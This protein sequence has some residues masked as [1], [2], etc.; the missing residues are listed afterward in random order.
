ME[1]PTPVISNT[2]N[3][4]LKPHDLSFTISIESYYKCCLTFLWAANSACLRTFTIFGLFILLSWSSQAQQTWYLDNVVFESGATATGSFDYDASTFAYTNIDIR[5]T[6]STNYG[7]P[8]YFNANFSNATFVI[9]VIDEVDLDGEPALYFTYDQALPAGGG[10]VNITTGVASSLATCFAPTCITVL[11]PY[12]TLVSGRVTTDPPPTALC[13]DTTVTLDNAGNASISTTDID[14][15]S[16]D[17]AAGFI[18]SLDRT[19]FTCADIGAN[20]VTLTVTDSNG[21]I[22]RCTATVTVTGSDTVAPTISCPADIVV[23]NDPNA[24]NSMVTVPAPTASDDCSFTLTND[25][26]GT[27]DAS[28][29]YPLGTTTV[30]WTATDVGGNQNTCSFT[31]TVNDTEA[32]SITCPDDIS[33]SVDSGMCN[34]IV[35]VPAP[36][37]SDNCSNVTI[38]NDFNNTADASGTY[39]TGTTTVTWTAT[40][41]VGNMTTCPQNI[42]VNDTEPPSITCAADINVNVDVGMCNA[43]LS[44]LAPVF[45]DNCPNATI[46]NDFT[47]TSDA[48]GSYP[49]GTTLVTWTA[50]DASGNSNTCIQRI[51]VTESVA[52]TISCPADSNPSCPQT[53]TYAS[54]TTTDN[55][56]FPAVPQSVPGFTLLGTFGDSTYFISN[57][58][59]TGAEAFAMAATNNYD[60]LTINSQEE[61]DYIFQQQLGLEQQGLPGS[62]GIFLGYNDVQTEGSFVW[63]SGQPRFFEN[64]GF[65]QPNPFIPSRDYVIVFNGSWLGRNTEPYPAVIEFHDYSNG[66]PIQVAGLPSGAFF[67]ETTVN[68]FF[69]KDVA[70]NTNTCSFTITVTDS[71]LPTISC[72]ADINVNVDPNA[73][74]AA[75]SVPTPTLGDD[76]GTVAIPSTY[77]VPYNFNMARELI[78]TPA[79]LVNMSPT[80]QDVSLR[81][82]FRGDHDDR[83]GFENFILHD[84]DNTLLLSAR[85]GECTLI[86]RIITIPMAT[87]NSWITNYGSDLTFRLQASALTNRDVCPTDGNYFQIDVISQ[88]NLLLAN[89]YTGTSSASAAYPIGTTK[90]S[91]TITDVAGNSS[92]CTQNITVNETETPNISCPADISV[93]TDNGLCTAVVNYALPTVT[94][95]CTLFSNTLENVLNNFNQNSQQVTSLIPDVF[96]FAMDGVNGVNGTQIDDGDI[97]FETPG[98]LD[99]YDGGNIISTDLDAGPINYSDNTITPSSAFGTNGAFF[100]R[101]VA[102]MWLL[103]ADLDN[104]N[105][106][107]INGDLGANSSG[108][109]DGFTSTITVGGSNY[110]LFVKRVREDVDNSP[111]ESDPSVNHLIIIPENT[112][113]AQNFSADTNNDQHQVTGLSGTTRMYYLLFASLNSG[114]VDNAT[115]EAMATSFINTVLTIPGTIQ[116]TAGLPSGS[117]FPFGT[118]T[119]TFVATDVGGNQ[120]SCSFTVTVN[121]PSGNCTVR[122]SPKVYLQGSTLNSTIA[123]DGLMRDDLRVNNYIPLNTPYTDN[124]SINSSVLTTTGADAIVDWVWVELREAASNTT[125]V[126]SKSALLQRDG[127]IVTLDGLSPLAFNRPNGNY[128]VVIKHRNHLGI[129]SNSTVA[130]ST[131]VS[132]IDFRDGITA[133]FGT[134]AQTTLGLP[135]GTFALWVGDTNGDKVIQYAGGIQDTPGILAEVLNDNGNFLNLPTFTATGYSDRDVNMDGN[136]QYSGGNSELSFILQNV[137]DDPRNFLNLSTWPINAQLPT[138]MVRAIQLRT[139]F[140]SSKY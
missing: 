26:T 9:F 1:I 18:L 6:N 5:V 137:L 123:A 69:S 21:S 29:V 84:P 120:S 51:A 129:M 74:T 81:I 37:V 63:Q 112:N 99:M 124:V 133:T 118:T 76:C 57:G 73:C 78:D 53:V 44:V 100:T 19:N 126:D 46:T 61:N 13:Q 35:T 103:A 135:N 40:D 32:P 48:S 45:S 131:S 92:S 105:S 96:D 8:P 24:C 14:A 49:A 138:T 10:T 50:T 140:E 80:A 114:L 4:I 22:D 106:F 33:T 85:G 31:V 2:S 42:T 110:N 97:L 71:S 125:V 59:M 117:V 111:F 39:P 12:E 102:N 36:I 52:P 58:I 64:W 91:W 132:I 25:F 93:N 27:S 16:T 98:T 82:R 94:D 107:N 89:D 87:W 115:V 83:E 56:S 65:F 104:M 113:A 119:N 121:N 79:L 139:N 127:D 88:G 28:G 134:N 11:P 116:Q 130:L 43:T 54:P 67:S 17:D 15:G 47:G 68:T 75:V 34:A 3:V 90:V 136:I 108:T 38:T 7:N 70:G 86:E 41:A 101:K 109:A 72:A 95:N 66:N 62:T 20:T 60:L 30:I 128:Y 23:N 122:V 55:C 77:K